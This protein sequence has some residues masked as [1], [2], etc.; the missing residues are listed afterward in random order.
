[1]LSYFILWPAKSKGS[2]VFTTYLAVTRFVCTTLMVAFL[3]AL[4]VMP[5]PRVVIGVVI[6][7]IWSVG[8]LVTIGNI[9]WNTALGIRSW[10]IGNDT[11]SPVTSKGSMLE[12]GT[13][14][15]GR[16]NG[17]DE[18]TVSRGST[19]TG[20]HGID[21]GSSSIIQISRDRP[22]NPTP[23]QNIPLDPAIIQPYPISPTG[24]TIST[25]DPPSLYSKSSGTMT[26]GSLLPSRWSISPS[27][28][29]SPLTSSLGHAS[30]LGQRNSLASSFM[31]P[32]LTPSDGG[33][34]VRNGTLSRNPS[35]KLQQQQRYEDIQEESEGS[36]RPH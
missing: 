7:V 25:I 9:I 19:S 22:I 35:L 36:P 32:P 27:Q 8:V 4:Q 21:L 23:E 16:P 28:P 5:I 15:S 17:L 13:D 18:R 12:K 24:T 2:H 1:M 31:P 14:D 29:T 11:S 26:V 6:V 34:S 20:S 3:Q 30:S 10:R 33:H